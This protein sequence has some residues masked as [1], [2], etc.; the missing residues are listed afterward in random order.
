MIKKSTLSIALSASLVD[1]S[2]LAPNEIR[3]F[4][5]GIFKAKD[6]RPQ[7]LPGWRIDSTIARAVI[8]SAKAQNDKFVIDYDHQ[9]IHQKTNGA[10]APAA[11]WFSELQWREGDGLYATDVEWTDTAAAAIEA[12]E[13]RYIS[14]VLTYDPKTGDVTG[15]LMAALVNFPA[16]DGLNDLAAAH[17][18]LYQ[19]QPTEEIKMDKVIVALCA[20]LGLQAGAAEAV[21]MAEL[22]KLKDQLTKDGVTATLSAALTARDSEIAALS[23]QVANPDPTK[24]V[25]IA[26]LAAVQAQVAELSTSLKADKVSA[27]VEAAL[28]DGRLQ[29]ALKDW[30]TKLGEKDFEALSAY[31][32]TLKPIAALNGL[33]NGPEGEGKDGALTAEQIAVCSALG[34]SQEDYA[35]TL[36]A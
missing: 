14:P 30:A 16:L 11:G 3:L 19:N 23:G 20:L 8:A 21:L 35:K 5:A 9:T 25:P 4:P 36:K 17:F 2:G 13:Y 28:S 33:Q 22:D 7:N 26:A 10:P 12:K 6:G 15:L 24:F 34:M 1:L 18:S 27:L 31:V 32:A 29:P